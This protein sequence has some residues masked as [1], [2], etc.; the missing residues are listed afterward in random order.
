MIGRFRKSIFLFTFKIIL[1]EVPGYCLIYLILTIFSSSFDA[2][3]V[4]FLAVSID[5]GM[6]LA[7][8]DSRFFFYITL[9]VIFL[10][11]LPLFNS[12]LDDLIYTK[13]KYK[14]QLSASEKIA[15]KAVQVPL[16]VIED[17]E[18]QNLLQQVMNVDGSFLLSYYMQYVS[19][20]YFILKFVF[21]FLVFIS[22]NITMSII[23][24]VNFVITIAINHI[25][26]TKRSNF[27]LNMTEEIRREDY[28]RDL[29]LDRKVIKD[30][31]LL[32][33]TEFFNS[34]FKD[35]ANT[36]RNKEIRFHLK[37]SRIEAIAEIVKIFVSF[38]AYGYGLYLIIMGTLSPGAFVSY[39]FTSNNLVAYYNGFLSKISQIRTQDVVMRKYKYF[40][41]NVAC[42]K[43]GSCKNAKVPAISFQHVSFR[44]REDAPVILN[45]I[46]FDLHAGEKVALVGANGSG[47]TTLIRLITSLNDKTEGEILIDGIPVEELD[48]TA[49]RDSISL[50]TQDYCKYY[51]TV[52]DNIGLSSYRNLEDD[53]ALADAAEKSGAYSFVSEFDKGL[54]QQVGTQYKQG[55]ELSGGQWQKL[56]LSRGYFKKAGLLIMDEPTAALD[57]YSEEKV[58]KQFLQLSK[59]HTAVFVSHRM[60][61]A[62]LADRILVLEN[63]RIVESGT[64]RQLMERH[65]LYAETYLQQA[66]LYS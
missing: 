3:S 31:K 65:G 21:A 18:Y 1:K 62:K 66:S 46:S 63:G 2:L 37:L 40:I 39:Y 14:L 61:S 50:V 48:K 24:L 26:T 35:C 43:S 22:F 29:M 59:D 9:Y 51:L 58:Y 52:R 64:H 47:K 28:Y 13:M 25:H 44:Y 42:E 53:Q 27:H 55:I 23:L 19:T 32:G 8:G 5:S 34:L 17:S 36:N 7:Q 11:I 54:D 56:A 38:F 4:K 30:A 15:D 41:E 45:D 57:A 33:T 60:A 20:V 16:N 6:H 49:Y 12:I 10:Y